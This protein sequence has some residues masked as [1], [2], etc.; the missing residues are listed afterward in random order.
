MSIVFTPTSSI[1]WTDSIV[2]SDVYL[3]DSIIS[4]VSPL[5]PFTP[6]FTTVPSGPLTI[7][8][9]YSKPLIGV[10]ETIDTNPEV[11]KKMLDYYYD[12]IRDDWLLDELNDVL[13]Y[14]TYR[15]GKVN[16][17]KNA[18]EYSSNNIVKDTDKIAEAKVEYIEKHIF[19]E[20]DL[21]KI[22]DKFTREVNCK[23][24]DLPKQ[25]FFLKQAIKEYLIRDIKKRLKDQKGGELVFF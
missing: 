1:V 18:S 21:M 8:F 12:L 25:S 17:I 9:N 15:D 6:V 22:L 10:Y 11:R 4:T 2:S 14:F 13:N 20:Y 23:W 7:S 3:T 5:T 16:M 24:V 19:T